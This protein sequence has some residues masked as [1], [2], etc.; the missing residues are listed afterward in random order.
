M[1]IDSKFLGEMKT[2]EE[3]K[4]LKG[5]FILFQTI[6]ED[7]LIMKLIDKHSKSRYYIINK[8]YEDERFLCDL[9]KED[10]PS[11]FF[12][13]INEINP[14]YLKKSD[15][16]MNLFNIKPFSLHEIF[17][18]IKHDPLLVGKVLT[19]IVE[20]NQ[21]MLKIPNSKKIF[22]L[23]DLEILDDNI[24]NDKDFLLSIHSVVIFLEKAISVVPY[25]LEYIHKILNN[26][27]DFMNKLDREHRLNDILENK[28]K[29]NLKRK[30][31]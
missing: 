25:Y 17:E 31:V 2:F 29:S 10:D 11:E 3:Y 15:N 27:N 21:E 24:V 14:I 28:E 13:N 22:H 12:Y 8:L 7:N 16:I 5:N 30:K 20:K 19:K 1:K 26:Y 4:N 23:D 6:E 18:Y 9:F